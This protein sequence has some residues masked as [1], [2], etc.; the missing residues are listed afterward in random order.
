MACLGDHVESCT[1]AMSSPIVTD[2][3]SAA[4][5]RRKIRRAERA[6]ELV[7]E[8]FAELGAAELPGVIERLA[9]LESELD[10]LRPP[11]PRKCKEYLRAAARARKGIMGIDPELVVYYCRC[12]ECATLRAKHK[13]EQPQARK[14]SPLVS[15]DAGLTPAQ[16]E[17]L[18]H[19][20][21]DVDD[22]EDGEAE[23][24]KDRAA[25]DSE[26][27]VASPT[28]PDEATQASSDPSA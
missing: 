8:A 14:L 15:D 21:D 2:E 12:F 26:P 16:V 5:L 7:R 10:R 6:I 20:E 4:E 27:P 11:E 3:A 19:D 17:E 23:L 24:A 1:G 13:L 22:D 18:S 28:A 9:G 25:L